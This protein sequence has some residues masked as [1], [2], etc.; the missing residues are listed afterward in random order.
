MTSWS[1]PA[2]RSHAVEP[3]H[4]LR[5]KPQGA[6]LRDFHKDQSYMRVL[7]GPLG[8][9]KTQASIVEILHRIMTQPPSK[10][11]IRKS[12]W[13]AVRNTLPDL[14]STTIKDLRRSPREWA[15]A[16]YNVSP[17]TC[18]IDTVGTDGIPVKAEILFRSFDS[19]LDEKKARGM[20]LTG[21]WLNELK[22][23][24]KGNVDMILS[25]VG[26][27]PAKAECR[28]AGTAPLLIVTAQTLTIGWVSSCRAISLITGGSVGS[29]V[30]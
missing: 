15:L 1:P 12:R 26:R 28:I 21:C 27:Y 23:L 17:V 25:R 7:V 30:R 2:A 13:L 8:S 4:R 18:T 16:P 14:E 5:Y 24:H 3:V 11:G 22:E 29:P 10:D 19:G 9:G 6:T 20:Q